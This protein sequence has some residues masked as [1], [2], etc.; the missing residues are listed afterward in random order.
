[1]K[2]LV[3]GIL[4]HVDSG[5]TTLSEALLYT[6]GSIRSLGRVDHGDA[7][8]DNFDIER[9]RGI[10]IFSKQAI[11]ETEDSVITLLDTPGH[12]DFSSET[13][14]TLEVLD[15]AI[16]VI[17]ATDGVQAHTETLWRLLE[18]HNIPVMVF[19]NKTDL[20]GPVEK[21][22]M[23]QLEARF[24][25]GFVDLGGDP[26][27]AAEDI[28]VLDEALMEKYLNTG[29]IA[30]DD[31]AS[32]ASQRRLFPCFFGS[33]LKLTGVKELLDAMG[34]YTVM[35]D[36][37]TDFGAQVFKITRGDRG[38]RLT[39]LKL[40][41][42][43]L[44]VKD[45][46]TVGDGEDSRQEKINQIRI[47]SGVRFNA[48]QAVQPGT[49]CAVTGPDGTYAGMGLGHERRSAPPVLEPVLTYRLEYPEEC[50]AGTM[51]G[52]MRQLEEEDPQLRVE[53]NE[54][55]GEIHLRLMGEV[56]LEVLRQLIASRFGVE[57]DFGQGSIAYMETITEP[58]EGI[59]HYEP[60]RHYAE[61][62]LLL[63]PG[64]PGSG[65]IFDS[66]CSVN[67]LDLNWQRLVLTHLAEKTHIGVLTGSPITDMKITLVAGRASI[68]QTEG[69][70]FRQ[71]T[72]RAV[73]QGLKRAESRLLEPWYA[74][75]IETP[76]EYI[77]RAISDIQQM[78]GS[79]EAPETSGDMAILNGE[80]PVAGLKDYQKELVSYTRGRGQI[81]FRVKG[82]YPCHNE[83]EVIETIG[84]D[85]DR[86]LEN[87][88]DS[89]FCA[90]GAGYNVPWYKVPSAAHTEDPIRTRLNKVDLEPVRER[91]RT[92]ELVPFSKEE[93]E[94]LARIFQMTYGTNVKRNGFTPV[95]K[96]QPK[97]PL[98]AVKPFAPQ[99][100]DEYLLVDGYN[101]IF[102]W[103]ELK[104]IA[105]TDLDAARA[106]LCDI[107][108]NYRGYRGSTVIVVFDAY[109]VR[110]AVEKV[111]QQNGIYVVYTKER[112]TADMYIERTTYRIARQNRVRVATSDGLEQMIILGHG[113]VRVPASELRQEVDEVNCHIREILDEQAEM[114]KNSPILKT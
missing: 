27:E 40:T 78:S 87:P 22:V 70:D 20:S 97:E 24:G 77:G 56:Q 16:L 52:Y 108:S 109:R 110:G 79:F 51:L 38:E 80:A 17:S 49:V 32:L 90:H 54:Q 19:V 68:K 26:A 58:V 72:Y 10:T 63:E 43:V 60:L 7:F 36:Y 111:E 47:Y 100:R 41:G 85:S 94:I 62:R 53:W 28:S 114:P 92:S 76:Q 25:G 39:H 1:M 23:A 11:L 18:R 2:R 102:A 106:R 21:A 15:Y 31:I 65:L 84:Y 12:V 35:P 89:I 93:E 74:F 50:P 71:A 59:G 86:D 95:R 30:D 3:F 75:R 9:Q 13:E 4:A 105:A 107:M 46:I 101:I 112:E 29:G 104:K 8:L 55:A 6:S 44:H 98:S 88:A 96:S 113:A 5:K 45:N 91:A 103:D 69:G 42:G 57:V 64:E 61:V 99:G 82:Y 37:P 73:R 67:Q 48:E 34:R 81:S 83:Q 66:N 33:A 14:R